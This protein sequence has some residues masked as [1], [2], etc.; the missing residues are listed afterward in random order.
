MDEPMSAGCCP[1]CGAP[2]VD[3]L[4]CRDQLGQLLAWEADDEE[5]RGVHFLTVASYNLQH[6]AW[7]TDEAI[8][9]LR[10]GFIDH[11]DRGVPVAELRRRAS[12]AV[13]GSKRVRRDEASVRPVR[14]AWPITIADVYHGCQPEGAAERVRQWAR[15]IRSSL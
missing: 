1:E 9:G 3:G 12:A 4:E 10:Q 13:E 5:L 2:R 15:A 14:R 7:F 11:L 8:A 6:P